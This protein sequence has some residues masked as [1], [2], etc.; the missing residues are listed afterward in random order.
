MKIENWERLA[1][2]NKYLEARKEIG[3]NAFKKL[4]S[5]AKTKCAQI[6]VLSFTHENIEAYAKINGEFS[7]FEDLFMTLNQSKL[8]DLTMYSYNEEDEFEDYQYWKFNDI[9]WEFIEV[10]LIDCF[11]LAEKEEGLDSISF[12]FKRNID[13]LE[14]LELNSCKMKFEKSEFEAYIENNKGN[15]LELLG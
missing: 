13:S 6:V 7:L 11:A 12:Y 2:I 9:V 3:I 4:I 10:W 5:R 1:K 8:D 14:V 15:L